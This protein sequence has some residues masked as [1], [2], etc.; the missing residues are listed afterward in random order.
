MKGMAALVLVLGIAVLAACGSTGHTVVE[1][2]LQPDARSAVVIFMQYEK[3]DAQV[4]DG[5]TPIGTF[6]GLS[7]SSRYVM[8]WKTTPGAHIFVV[9]TTNFAHKRMTLQAGRTYYFRVYGV[10]AGP[11]NTLTFIAIAEE[12]KK[13]YDEFMAKSNV[14]KTT[15]IQFD[16][17]WRKDFV[18]ANDGK[19]LNDI[20]EY[21]KKAK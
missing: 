4:W 14:L 5:E 12:N 17:D 9:R 6:K 7:R 1:E 19:W 11:L 13:Y 2:P 18:T 20:R 21:I 16:D 3:T 8:S 10:A 15:H